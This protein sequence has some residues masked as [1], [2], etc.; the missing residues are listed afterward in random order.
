[1]TIPRLFCALLAL[2][3]CT[4]DPA[5]PDDTNTSGDADTD[6]DTDS[7]T[8]WDPE[9]TLC[10]TVT[11]LD[12]GCGAPSSVN[13]WTIFDGHT[14]CDDD[15]I[16]GDTGGGGSW[17]DWRDTLS[18]APAVASSGRFESELAAGDYAVRLLEQCYGCTAF[19]VTDGDCAEVEL[20]YY[21]PSY[22]DA[23]NVYIYP[24]QL[25]GVRV[26]VAG[27]DRITASDPLYPRGGWTALAWP[28]GRLL[29][30]E[31][32][33][34]F[35]FYETALPDRYYQFSEGWCAD[36][37][38]AQLSIEDAMVHY[39][40]LDDEI[41]DFS[42]FWDPVFPESGQV[43]VYPQVSDLPGL[44]IEP[45]PDHTLRV[46]FVVE[47][48]CH[49][50]TEPTIEEAIRQGFHAAEWGVVLDSDIRPELVGPAG[51]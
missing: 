12:T 32:T 51:F 7:D 23:P 17:V 19:S 22:A 46:W 24:E 21:E 42:E 44:R 25:T 9:S 11:L 30:S 4:K 39:G 20:Q 14:A 41:A 18:D 1:M 33:R 16:F 35:L 48:G 2:L 34:D 28:D 50:V 8:D 10:G 3:A 49:A 29:T 36:G 45:R 37:Q 31:G 38:H 15:A 5:A 40:F 47:P 13:V 6:T 26:R 43:T 27:A